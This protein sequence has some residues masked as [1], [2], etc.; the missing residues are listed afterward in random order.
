M[1]PEGASLR[2]Y[3]AK[4]VSDA[5]SVDTGDLTLVQQHFKDEVDVNAIVRRFGLVPQL[6]AWNRQ[7]VYG[8]FTGVTDFDSAVERIRS[9]EEAFMR[10]PAEVRD[11][12][13]NDPA[14]LVRY[15]Q[16]VS[17]DEFNRFLSP[18]SVEPVVE[19]VAPESTPE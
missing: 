14:E 17:E 4:A 11:K 12:F 19:P 13:A 5:V 8:D 1:I 10:L 18:A 3:D 9:T 16:S 15:A 2:G 7:G 6:P